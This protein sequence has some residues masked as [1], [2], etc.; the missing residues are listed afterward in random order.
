MSITIENVEDGQTVM[1]VQTE[2]GEKHLIL[3]EDADGMLRW[4][5]NE[6]C[7]KCD[8]HDCYGY[9]LIGGTLGES[10]SFSV[11]DTLGLL[12][13]LSNAA[14]FGEFVDYGIPVDFV[15]SEEL[16]A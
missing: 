4:A 8:R 1:V 3:S 13:E 15:Y 5:I 11:T 10:K 14:M 16:V 12:Q 2:L 9:A 7:H 6:T